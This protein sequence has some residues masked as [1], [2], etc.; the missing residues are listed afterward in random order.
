M[1]MRNEMIPQMNKYFSSQRTP[2]RWLLCWNNL[3]PARIIATPRP[4]ITRC[5]R[6]YQSTASS[7]SSSLASAAV[8]VQH[9]QQPSY[10]SRSPRPLPPPTVLY[11]DN[12]L[13]VVNKPVRPYFVWWSPCCVLLCSTEYLYNALCIFSL[14][15]Y[16]HVHPFV[17]LCVL[18]VGP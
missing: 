13:L 3:V 1:R 7:S 6:L 11:S 12:H 9:P 17:F 14:L 16:F 18:C 8:A 4:T 5:S 10:S 15:H 2:S